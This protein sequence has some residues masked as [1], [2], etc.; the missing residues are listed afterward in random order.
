MRTQ[1]NLVGQ[2][3]I[4]LWTKRRFV[5][6]LIFNI[7]FVTLL[8]VFAPIGFETNDDIGMAHL[9]SGKVLGHNEYHLPFINVS[10][11][12]I[13][14]K[15]YEIIPCIEWYTLML[16][17]FHVISVTIIT[18]FILNNLL[19]RTKLKGILSI[20]ILYIFEILWLLQLQFT[21][22]AAMLATAG[23][24]VI[25][26]HRNVGWGIL[27]FAIGTLLRYHSAM[28]A[29]LIFAACYPLIAFNS[30]KVAW[31]NVLV[32]VS[33]AIIGFGTHFFNKMV[34][35]SN[36]EWKAYYEYNEI[37]G[38]V[39]DNPNIWRAFIK[40][41]H[42][43]SREEGILWVDFCFQ[44]PECFT[45]DDLTK[46]KQT[47]DQGTVF[48]GIPHVKK[49]KS[50]FPYF[51]SFWKY[52]L[53]LFTLSLFIFINCK[54]KR[55]RLYVVLL[56]LLI[57]V[58]I[59]SIS[60]D[61]ELKERA[62]FAILFPLFV[63]NYTFLSQKNGVWYECVMICILST[64]AIN[65]QKKAISTASN[66]Q[67]LMQ[68]SP[69]ELHNVNHKYTASG[70]L[71]NIPGLPYP[72]GFIDVVDCSSCVFVMDNSSADRMFELMSSVYKK[73]YKIQVYQEELCRTDNT[74]TFRIATR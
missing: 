4:T 18:H 56:F 23:L 58:L 74:L 33:C 50:A 64:I 7:L 47:I 32:L 49:L 41:P 31:G 44:D 17:A 20:L 28:C 46:M 3:L 27:L 70:W 25:L 30:G 59:V 65:H 45:K 12:W 60:M 37:R 51:V 69:W 19:Q 54:E 71:H 36:P 1:K 5:C 34:Y 52:I 68:I 72:P 57:L 14:A 62:L 10:L 42:G 6:I 61:A 55:G 67:D 39:F 43:L 73:K 11:G 15:L 48:H 22:T 8:Q 40:M 21:T 26:N 53:F 2:C 29:G 38:K 35:Y 63:F 66:N 13:L 24:V 16:I 9:A